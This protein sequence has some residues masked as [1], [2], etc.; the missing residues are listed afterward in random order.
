MDYSPTDWRLDM[1][2]RS[3]ALTLTGVTLALGAPQLAHAEDPLSRTIDSLLGKSDYH[4]DQA[5][6][7]TQEAIVHGQAGHAHS[8]AHHARAALMNAHAQY[9][10]DQNPHIAEAATHLKRS[11]MV[12]WA[13]LALASATPARRLLISML[14]NS[15]FWP[16]QSNEFLVSCDL[17][18]LQETI[19]LLPQSN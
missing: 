16:R 13:M 18:D 14:Q 7:H 9:H 17:T 11:N 2:N 19:T 12:I 8:L 10:G 6:S 5:I 1:I 3:L 4:L 15:R